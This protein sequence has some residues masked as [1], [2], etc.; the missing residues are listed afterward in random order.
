[1]RKK[2]KKILIIV[3]LV[4]IIAG[5]GFLIHN[6]YKTVVYRQTYEFK[7]MEHGYSEAS[8]KHLEN[9]FDQKYL[10]FLLDQE[11]NENIVLFSKDNY[12]IL[13]NLDRYLAYFEKSENK[14]IR[15]TVAVVNSNADREFYSDIKPTNTNIENRYLVLANKFYQLPETF[16]P[17]QLELISTMYAYENR[18]IDSSIYPEF[19]SMW[20]AAKKEDLTL[21]VVSGFRDFE[22]QKKIY[23]NF[24]AT[25]GRGIAEQISARPG[26]SEHQLG[27]ALDIV[28]HGYGLSNNFEKSE[29]FKWLVD[30]AHKY[31]FILRYP[32]NAEHIT[33]YSY[34]PWHY[35]YVGVEVATYIYKNNIT[36]DEYYAYYLAK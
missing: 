20:N 1:M 11:V 32:N 12:F 25:Q 14:E 7:L 16:K 15:N 29:E 19:K 26:H 13:A 27:F 30:N 24:L 33:G 17:E 28:T 36:F 21:I 6:I 9:F 22:T 10:D 31:G 3:F 5:L 8:V 35:R 4:I 18:Y 34:E 2:H 23:N